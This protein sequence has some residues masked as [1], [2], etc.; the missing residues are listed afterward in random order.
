MPQF[1]L[2]AWPEGYSLPSFDPASLAT[3]A[4]LNLTQADYTLTPCTT[5][6][7]SPSGVLPL[8]VCG[9]EPTSGTTN[10]T[11]LLANAGLTLDFELTPHQLALQ[12]ALI[13]MVES[14]IGDALM[15]A[16][17]IS[18]PASH[19][20]VIRPSLGFMQRHSVPS[21]MQQTARR[22]MQNTRILNC[23]GEKLAECYIL[24]R[25]CFKALDTKLGTKDYFFG[26]R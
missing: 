15:Y 26:D 14:Q 4:L 7:I 9:S 21:L 23:A 11:T 24:S 5:P 6:H 25:D 12:T 19:I 3:I 13:A 8:L 2:Y 22:R 18:D 16:R 20:A 1:E 17:F 10:I